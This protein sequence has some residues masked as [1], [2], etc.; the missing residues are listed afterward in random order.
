MFGILPH[1]EVPVERTCKPYFDGPL[2]SRT[3]DQIPEWTG[4]LRTAIQPTHWHGLDLI[5][6]NLSLY[7]AEFSLASRVT[8]AAQ[9]Q[10]TFV[11]YEV[12]REALATV[13]DDYDVVLLDTAPSL[14]FVNSNALF[15]ADALII[16]LPPAPL[17]TQS[18]SLFYELIESVLHTVYE[19]QG[20]EKAYEFGAVLLTR[21]RP[22]DSNHQL[23]A[24]W[25]RTYLSDTFTN[26]MVQTVVLEKL[27]TKMLTLYETD[28]VDDATKY[29]GDRRAFDRALESMNSVNGEIERMIQGVWARRIAEAM[30]LL[31]EGAVIDDA[32]R[33]ARARLPGQNAGFI[34]TVAHFLLEL[35]KHAWL[36][37][38]LAQIEADALA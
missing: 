6:S 17:D 4:T 28:P 5:A 31:P 38:E 3:G 37:R 33:A 23:I 13:K 9:R 30:T 11:F 35:S 1:S 16:T 36:E 12:L 14:S 32:L 25:I 10:E 2:D 26:P 7:G 34:S 27:G 29:E 15:A 24:S 8:A 21:M 19:I 18:A 22:S 20:V